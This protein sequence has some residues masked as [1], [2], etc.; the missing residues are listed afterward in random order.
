MGET[1]R[2]RC[3]IRGDVQGVGFRW[4]VA[5]RARAL[6]L[7]GY[8]RNL[9]DG[10]VEVVA[11]GPPGTVDALRAFCTRGP[12]GAAVTSVDVTDQPATGEYGTFVVEP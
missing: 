5:A 7:T 10:Q 1:T 3:L 2:I 4:S 9:A 8:V 12:T 6:R 11:E